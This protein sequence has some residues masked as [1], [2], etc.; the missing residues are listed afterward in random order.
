MKEVLG[1]SETSV[2]TRA[3]RRNI[4]EDTILHNG[5]Y[6]YLTGNTLRLRYGAPPVNAIY[7]LVTMVCWYN[8]HNSGHYPSSCL[9][10]KANISET[11]FFLHFQVEPTQLGPTQKN[12][13]CLRSGETSTLLGTLE[14]PN[15]P[16]HEEK[17]VQFAKRCFLV[18]LN[19]QQRTKFSHSVNPNIYSL[20]LPIPLFL[21]LMTYRR[22][23]TSSS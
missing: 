5:K 22:F 21:I 17:K 7:R 10:F 3:T 1:C 4:P 16:S 23:S 20:F 11:G 19:S 13:L 8:Y 6:S 18:I 9:L 14:R 15:L 2:L 12:S